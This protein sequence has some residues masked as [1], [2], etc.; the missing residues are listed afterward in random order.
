MKILVLSIW[1]P[2][3]GGI[4]THVENIVKNSSFNYEIVGYPALPL[5][6][7]IRAVAYIINAVI[8][9]ISSDYQIIHAHYVFPQG[10]AGVI[11]KKITKKPLVLTVHGSD[12]NVFASTRMGRWI[13]EFV[14][15]NS[16]VV[17]AV[18]RDLEKKAR[19]LGAQWV[20]V[21]YGAPKVERVERKPSPGNVL[22]V[23]SCAK[24]KGLE[25]LL[26]AFPLVR[27][28]VK[29]A[30]LVVV[31]CKKDEQIEGVEFVGYTDRVQEYYSKAEVVVIPSLHE[32][33]SLVALEAL[34]CGIPIVASN[35]GGLRE[36]LSGKALLVEPGNYKQLAQAIVDVLTNSELRE[37][38]SKSQVLFTGKAL[39]E[40]MEDIYRRVING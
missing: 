34:A 26:R 31:G 20:E 7:G 33:L 27:E 22:F 3:K 10:F 14:I 16:N 4:V 1:K 36:I 6:K 15:K 21:V 25:V 37:K 29:Y 2:A 23:G 8:R 9:S 39:A 19:E 5:F 13:A 11:L 28:R 38:L 32:G 12:L 35:T 24:Q 30:K 40:K 18:S 17:C